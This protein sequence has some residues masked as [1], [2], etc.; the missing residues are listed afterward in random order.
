M[1][2]GVFLG[3]VVAL[4][5]WFK[6]LVNWIRSHL[7]LSI[8]LMFSLMSFAVCVGITLAD[9]HRDRVQAEQVLSLPKKPLMSFNDDVSS[10]KIS[11]VVSHTIRTGPWY[12]SRLE[13]YMQ[14][15]PADAKSPSYVVA[16]SDD[17][18]EETNKAIA[19][20]ASRSPISIRNG[21]RA[22]QENMVL[23][24]FRMVF[25][26]MMLVG[27]LLVAQM[28]IGEVMT[29]HSF[30]AEKPDRNITFDSIAGYEDVKEQ[31]REIVEQLEHPAR[32]S[33][34]GVKA[35]KGV[36][37]LGPPG[38][39]KTM[40][41]K[42]MANELNAASFSVTGADFAE[43]YVGVGPR[44]VRSLFRQ[45]RRAPRALIF[46]DEFDA[47]GSRDAMGYDTERRAT[48]NKL[49]SEL[50]GVSENGRLLVVAATNYAD[51]LDP[52]L[53]RPG[54]IDRKITMDLPD[55]ATRRELIRRKLDQG[56]KLR[57]DPSLDPVSLARRTEGFSGAEICNVLDEARNLAMRDAS[58][59][60]SDAVLTQ[61]T[62]EQAQEIALLGSSSREA[63]PEDLRRVAVHELGH[64]LVGHVFDGTHHVEKVTV[65]GR[66]R[67]AGFTTS[68]SVREAPIKTE[69]ELRGEIAFA[70][71][72][73]A[74]EKV[75]L[76]N[77]SAGA[78]DDLSR[79][80]RIAT[81]MVTE[82]G[83]GR[84]SGL[85]VA[86]DPES[87]RSDRFREE[88]VALLD[89]IY[90]EVLSFTEKNR[91]WYED[92]IDAVLHQGILN[93]ADL[94]ECGVYR[95]LG[96]IRRGEM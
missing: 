7:V 82:L 76:G 22:G 46:I 32:F 80:T 47:I 6:D 55:E 85:A 30:K 43:M 62:I 63:A 83:M 29:G 81:H 10:G 5:K 93:H 2:S 69:G 44:R 53:V 33:E 28:L 75:L 64:A 61:A 1:L 92:R 91:A 65:R 90:G 66:G 78:S 11:E 45:A 17:L 56:G 95:S 51:H 67:A 86:L 9:S 15:V 74:A 23:G 35:P 12:L 20:A 77:V 52:A 79:A 4:K 37:L 59:T 40:M 58:R 54:R 24:V 18:R 60:G 88:V 3:G 27:V 41:A 89:E 87:A 13:T 26:V 14:A 34:H 42:A 96:I 36:L 49:L 16:L 50:D 21:S 39:G 94:F 8:A 19:L 68:I 48:I 25:L 72:G 73:R 38:V 70:L 31:F 84:K 57:I 71:G